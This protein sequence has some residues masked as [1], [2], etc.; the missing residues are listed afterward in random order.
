LNN[1]LAF[2]AATAHDAAAPLIDGLV[3][4]TV[5]TARAGGY[6]QKKRQHHQYTHGQDSVF[7]AVFPRF[8][9]PAIDLL[10]FYDKFAKNAW[11]ALRGMHC[12]HKIT[13]YS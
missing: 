11:E 2:A 6:G 13:L 9:H 4:A 7:S 3:P 8:K 1:S 5:I 12:C 10:Q